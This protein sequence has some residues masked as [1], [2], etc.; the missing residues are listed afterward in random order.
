M[1]KPGQPG[2]ATR[3]DISC[4]LSF[5]FR[6]EQYVYDA[7]GRTIQV[8]QPNNSGSATYTYAGNTVTSTDAANKWKTF[9][10]D[11]LGNLTK[12]TEP[13]PAGGANLETTYTYSELAQL[14]TVSMPRGGVTQTRTFVY[15]STTQ[16]LTSTTN[17]ENGT[18]TNSIGKPLVLP[19][20]LEKV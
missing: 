20:R 10:S 9:E 2:Q 3:K 6:F 15:N 1:A 18:T 7:L 11:A 12:V 16:R 5:I 14:L 19:V 17:P 4:T 8:K 13:N